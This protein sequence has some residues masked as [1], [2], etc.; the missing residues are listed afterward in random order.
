MKNFLWS[1]AFAVSMSFLS[2]CDPAY[3]IRI[4]NKTAEPATIFVLENSNFRSD[5]LPLGN[6]EDGLKI[7]ILEPDQ[8]L[9]VGMAIADL[10]D[11][12]PFS[13]LIVKTTSDSISAT[14][15]KEMKD[16][17]DKGW[18]GN[19]KKPYQITIEN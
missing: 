16:L 11:D 9:N 13:Q 12:M 2:S 8:T 15:F 17:F 4:T 19:L 1:I 3:P 10:E 7:Y 18:L 14:G 6:N 5:K